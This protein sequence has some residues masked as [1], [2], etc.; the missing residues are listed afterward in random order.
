[1][2]QRNQVFL[3]FSMLLLLIAGLNSCRKDP[4]YDNE[5]GI[6]P[7][8]EEILFD[9]V[10]TTIGS[11]S[12][13][14]YIRNDSD[15][16]V[17]TN[18]ELAGGSS[19]N[20]RVNV[21][22]VAGT[23]FEE[24]EIPAHDSLFIFVKV[25]VNPSSSLSPFVIRDSLVFNTNGKIQDVKLIAWGQNAHYIVPD[26][27]L[28]G[29]LEYSIVSG[30]GENITWTNDLPYLVYGYAVIDSTGILNIDPG[31]RIHFYNGSGMWVYKGGSLRVNGTLE[32][33]V[34]FQGPRLEQEYAEVPG[35]WDRIWINEGAVNNV[36]NYAIIKNGFIGIQAET[37]ES[38]MGNRLILSN[39][40]I[41][42]MT[43]IGLLSKFYRIASYNCTYSNCAVYAVAL[44]TGGSYDFRHCTIGNYWSLSTR[45]T[46]SLLITDYYKDLYNGTIY[47]GDLDSA[48]F[49]NSIIYGNIDNEL[50]TDSTG[51]G[52]FN[53][54][55]E[56][57][58]I[59]T[60]RS[61][62]D[63][64]RFSNV[65]ANEDP[66]FADVS[67]HNYRL[68]AGSAAIDRGAAGVISS[69]LFDL[70]VDLL[71]NN[72]LINPPPDLGAIDY[73]P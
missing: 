72:R 36:I 40:E 51:T 21:D 6:I 7:S 58:L 73:R 20:F 19:S 39:T 10:F 32:E 56:N 12:R 52:V 62:E 65:T 22:G 34:T 57:C 41:R 69:S 60:G 24:V 67:N 31:V 2:R 8:Q 64:L 71:G 27:L 15:R 47:S 70:S 3:V 11:T 35:Q 25:T 23:R 29:S 46:P 42:N 48:Y 18:I 50:F 68:K 4:V 55:F 13:M 30:E 63:P 59:R 61:L 9:T 5:A 26:H 37:V 66:L 49:G 17:L 45:Q 43:G 53:Y 38:G 54:F 14:F 44:T 33:P 28:G 16:P 1:M